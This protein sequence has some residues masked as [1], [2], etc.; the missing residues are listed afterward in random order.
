NSNAFP[1]IFDLERVEVLRGPQGTLFGAGA[2]GGA[3]RFIL[4][5]PGLTSYSSYLRGDLADT[6][7]GSPS[8]ELGAAVGGPII[9]D[10][11]GFRASV[12]G[13]NEGGYI[14]RV[15]P[16]TGRTVDANSNSRQSV[17]GRLALGA[18]PIEG[19]KL[20]G[21]VLYQNVQDHDRGQYWST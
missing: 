5:E 14:D 20:T 4:P 3:V 6:I 12:W 18:A 17:V 7:D 2:E 13:R 10:A 15:S 9:K 21:S 1:E 11:L 16:D 19:L 8:Y